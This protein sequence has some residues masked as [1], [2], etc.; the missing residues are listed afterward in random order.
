MGPLKSAAGGVVPVDPSDYTYG[1]FVNFPGDADLSNRRTT[2]GI[3][4]DIR[5]A[6]LLRPLAPRLNARSDTFRIRAFGETRDKFSGDVTSQVVCEAVVQRLPEYVDP[7]TDAGNNEP[8]D[9]ATNPLSPTASAL[10]ATNQEFGRRFKIVNIRWLDP[11][12]I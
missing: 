10:N 8:W 11:S 7:N 12:E 1:G 6:D 2:E 4:G 3:A 9:E 5:Q